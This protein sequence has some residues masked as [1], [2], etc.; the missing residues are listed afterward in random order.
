MVSGTLGQLE[1]VEIPSVNR[2][3]NLEEKIDFGLRQPIGFDSLEYPYPLFISNV[4]DWYPLERIISG[5]DGMKFKAIRKTIE[6]SFH[7]IGLEIMF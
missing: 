3:E 6:I 7:P 4:T 2:V 1:H 5:S